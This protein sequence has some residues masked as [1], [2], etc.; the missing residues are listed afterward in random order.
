MTGLSSLS[1]NL[2]YMFQEAGDD[3]ASRVRAASAA[4][5]TK[6]EMFWTHDKDLDAIAAALDE[7]GIQLWTVLVDPRT[8]RLVD[9]DSHEGFLDAVRSTAA[10]AVRLGC[11]HVVVGSGPAVPYLKRP[12]QIGIVTD[13]IRRAVDIA[14]EAD[15]TLLVEA[16]KEQQALIGELSTRVAA[17]E[18]R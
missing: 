13:V 2:E 5:F 4:G 18:A 11:P 17:C 1:V 6:A 12:V 10:D 7:T 3:L 14:E 16:V 15:V 8:T 9:K